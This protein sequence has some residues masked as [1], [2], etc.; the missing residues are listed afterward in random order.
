MK[1]I[2]M[3]YSHDLNNNCTIIKW[4][5][6]GYFKTD[7]PEGKYTDEVINMMN[8]KLSVSK[9]ERYAMELC[10][11]AKQNNPELDWNEH[12]EKVLA[13]YMKKN[14]EK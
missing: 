13:A 6:S 5:E 3:C 10:S 8:E 12:Y 2:E 11:M 1:K 4:D 9:E 14:K 7:F